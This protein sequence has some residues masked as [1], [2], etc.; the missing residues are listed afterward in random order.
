M[1]GNE[2]QTMQPA[3]G[4]RDSERV[5]LVCRADELR[6]YLR[7]LSS[8]IADAD[9][10]HGDTLRE[11]RDRLSRIGECEV[12]RKDIAPHAA[13]IAREGGATGET[14][15]PAAGI[16]EDAG[17]APPPPAPSRG[18]GMEPPVLKSAIK[19]GHALADAAG[20]S[21]FQPAQAASRAAEAPGEEEPWDA[22]SVAALVKIYDAPETGL[23]Q[24][25]GG[26]NPAVE[27]TVGA[28]SG[29][30]V[31]LAQPAWERAASEAT[32]SSA[33]S[34]ASGASDL[35][36]SIAPSSAS[37]APHLARRIDRIAALLDESLAALRGDRI[38]AELNA[39]FATLE[40]A[41]AK[42]MS[43]IATRTDVAGLRIVEAHIA[44]LSERIEKAQGHLARLDAI[45]AQVADLGRKLSDEGLG[46]LTGGA[47]LTEEQCAR[48]AEEAA[49]RAVRS[50]G[51]RATGGRAAGADAQVAEAARAI[52]DERLAAL[53]Q[54]LSG[55][56]DERRQGAVETQEALTTLQEAMQVMLDRVEAMES[57]L[58]HA[59][60]ATVE[61]PRNPPAAHAAPASGSGEEPAR[62]ST[63][64]RVSGAAAAETLV[65]ADEFE[66]AKAAARAAKEAASR[67]DF[68]GRRW[69][70]GGSEAVA[71]GEWSHRPAEPAAGAAERTSQSAAHGGAGPDLRSIREAQRRAAAQRQ[72]EAESEPTAA[73]ANGRGQG[74]RQKFLGGSSD[75]AG[76]R[77]SLLLIP[78]VLLLLIAGYWFLVAPK[79][80][81]IPPT[82]VRIELPDATAPAAGNPGAGDAPAIDK[83][84]GQ[85]RRSSPPGTDRSDVPGQRGAGLGL[86][87]VPERDG[88]ASLQRVG[89]SEPSGTV[90]LPT[91]GIAVQRMGAAPSEE[92]LALSHHRMHL[93]ALSQRTAENAAEMSAARPVSIPAAVR[94]SDE[95]PRADDHGPAADQPRG[96][97]RT[98]IELPP[99]AVGP[100]SLRL[101]A[102]KGDPSAQFQ[103]GLRFAEG[104]GV[105][106]DLGQA[107]AW[108]Q[109]AAAQG[110][111][112]A[113]YRLAALF[114]R[115]L[116]VRQD[117][118]RARSWYTRAAEQG[119][120]KAMHN[121]A[122]LSAGRDAA[123]GDYA[124]AAK[125]FEAAA[126][127]GLADSQYNLGVLNE[128]GLGVPKN[129]LAAYKWYALAAGSG[130]K[131]AARRRDALRGKL[132][133][134]AVQTVD[135]SVAAWRP[136]PVDAAINDPIMAGTAWQRRAGQ[137]ATGATN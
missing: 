124:S 82:A 40:T 110:L 58:S 39:R 79:G 135:E 26:G 94:Q 121:L 99:A 5:G 129:P 98:L 30:G 95:S 33:S 64:Q 59:P 111:A 2:P 11:L 84:D 53:Q 115:G 7:Q 46:R 136:Q 54:L 47:G 128:S 113:Q 106:R 45:E 104:K 102:A 89:D 32:V 112:A 107:A 83:D 28:D 81:G 63:P 80:R 108:Y 120:V 61:A 43:D 19:A 103:I 13:A 78:S 31:G 127:R 126:E 75:A 27:A 38:L 123:T 4:G 50:A 9:R 100:M 69:G 34:N 22:Q 16:G 21:M 49:E 41:W 65:E 88:A 3:A 73:R 29:L 93:A 116:G 66:Q 114:E 76:S 18:P 131:E 133:P 130:D 91:A 23:G 44:D 101:A 20:E 56:I 48:I 37:D 117:T 36:S 1:A 77:S 42:A 118:A 134:A 52:A 51:E 8:Q 72:L 24:T 15:W 17:R 85:D 132:D 12:E 74:L 86:G 119:H 70:D 25:A 96:D 105:A 60:A 62:W 71:K 122:V 97:G 6:D 125:W 92:E 55:F 109:R 67:G 35:G 87:R 57:K 68:D 90:S 137:T 14:S 10:R